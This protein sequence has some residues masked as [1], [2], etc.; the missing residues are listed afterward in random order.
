M[1]GSGWPFSDPDVNCPD[2]ALSGLDLVVLS[3]MY[4]KSFPPLSEQLC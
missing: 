2:P 4:P 3:E 1:A